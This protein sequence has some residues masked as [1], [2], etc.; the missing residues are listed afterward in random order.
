MVPVSQYDRHSRL[1]GSTELTDIWTARYFTK[2]SRLPTDRV[3]FSTCPLD[4]ATSPTGRRKTVE[5]LNRHIQNICT[6]AAIRTKEL[7]TGYEILELKETAKLSRFAAQIY[8]LLLNFY[9][10]TTP[11]IMGCQQKHPDVRNKALN[12]FGIPE[13]DTLINILDPY[14]EVF[15][16]QQ[17]SPTDW[18]K[19]S[20][21]TTQISISNELFLEALNSVEQVLLKPYFDFLEEYVGIPWQR[22]CIAAE[23]HSCT[24]STF[25]LVE[26]MLLKIPEISIAVYRKWCQ[27]F[28]HYY[29]RRGRLDHP[30]VV[31]SALRDFDMFQVYLWICMLEGNL[32]AIEQELLLL[33]TLVYQGIGI[34]W[35]MTVR[36]VELLIGEILSHLDLNEQAQAFP[37]VQQMLTAFSRVNP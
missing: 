31:N 4:Y 35:E 28:S 29:G 34:P 15:K 10:T 8:P 3:D 27:Q 6:L 5:K 2:N 19:R 26:K 16:S 18:Q 1:L 20:F 11:M 21:L 9:Q 14:L 32:E 25:T 7:Y 36:G 17:D 22:L 37:Y 23:N 24:S 12:I 33:C 13:M 30:S